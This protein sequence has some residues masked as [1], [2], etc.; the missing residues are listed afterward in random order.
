MTETASPRD[1]RDLT[2]AE[3]VLGLLDSD[4]AREALRRQADDLEFAVLVGKWQRLTEQWLAD[5]AGEAPPVSVLASIEQRLDRDAAMVSSVPDA[6]AWKGWAIA[7]M[8]AA[9]VLAVALAL[10]LTAWRPSRP[11]PVVPAF[12]GNVTQINDPAGIPL[13][14]AVY[15]RAD[16]TLSLRVAKLGDDR[17]VPELWVIAPGQAPRSLGLLPK[18]TVKISVSPELRAL[19]VEGSS[20]AI[21]LEPEE[22]APHTAPSGKILGAGKLQAL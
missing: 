15:Q 13:L 21:T 5:P 10:T 12:A 19:L 17:K 6:P 8:A 3:L 11:V 14:S 16:G 22:G 4:A 18:D 2:A 7:S 1:E 9:V 20:L